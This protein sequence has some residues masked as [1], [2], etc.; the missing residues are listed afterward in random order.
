MG[1]TLLRFFEFIFDVNDFF[2]VVGNVFSFLT[3][4]VSLVGSVF[5]I[6]LSK[7]KVWKNIFKLLLVVTLFFIFV[8]APVAFYVNKYYTKV[9]CVTDID[10]R[11][12]KSKISE[13]GLICE[14]L[15]YGVDDYRVDEQDPEEDTFVKKGSN[16]DVT[17]EEREDAKGLTD[18]Q[19]EY[20]D[21]GQVNVVVEVKEMLGDVDGAKISRAITDFDDIVVYLYEPKSDIYIR[22]YNVSDNE[23]YFMDIPEKVNY[24]L[25]VYLEGYEVY[26]DTAYVSEEKVDSVSGVCKFV[27]YMPIASAVTCSKSIQIVND[28]GYSLDDLL[29]RFEF[30]G[31]DYI[32]DQF[33]VDSH[34]N[35][36]CKLHY[37][38]DLEMTVIVSSELKD[39]G[40]EGSCKVELETY[41]VGYVAEEIQIRLNADGSC[42]IE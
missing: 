25:Y 35:V 23:F 3:F 19:D 6:N 31:L 7:K 18:L 42:K 30:E 8:Y 26:E 17:L 14:V 16:V 10:Y 29:V 33:Y 34:G 4:V 13:A 37:Y 24:D 15:Y 38:E 39:D 22:D 36:E 27:A 1:N 32:G 41:D 40:E 11:E 9:P 12:A 20:E 2:G 28:S 21:H 5:L